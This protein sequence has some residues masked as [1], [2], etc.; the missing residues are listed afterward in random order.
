MSIDPGT[1]PRHFLPLC[2]T[3]P[4]CLGAAAALI[5]P[6]VPTFWLGETAP[7][8]VLALIPQASD[9]LTLSVLPARK[10]HTLLGQEC[11]LLVFDA[12]SG[13]DVNAFAA[14][15][16][17][18]VGGGTLVLLSP[19]WDQWPAFP[20]P[21]YRRF[22]PWPRTLA[23]VR[24]RFLARLVRVLAQDRHRF[25]PLPVRA[26][27]AFDPA[28]GDAYGM[29]HGYGQGIHQTSPWPAPALRVPTPAQQAAMDT[30]LQASAPVTLTADRGRG[31]SALLGLL[32]TRLQ[33]QGRTPILCAP[34][35]QTAITALRHAVTAPA[36]FAPDELLQTLPAAD[37]LLVDEAAAIPVPLLA[38]MV[39]HYPR[40]V[41][42]TTVHGYE[43]S[44]RGF[45]LRFQALLASLAPG[46]QALRLE[47]P[48]RWVAGDALEA[49][50]NRVLLLDLEL[51]G[52]AETGGL[53]G[54][55]DV[56]ADG[57]TPM[58]LDRDR[59]AWDEVL[60]QQ[61][62]GLLVT[63]HY[64]TRPSDL[65]QL[66][67]APGLSVHAL[68]QAGQVLAVGVLSREGGFDPA[69]A[70]AIHTGQRRPHGHPVPQSL[71][72]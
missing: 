55:G 24:G 27:R 65:R 44:G 58:Q 57:I 62:F 71:C 23:D 26:F 34:S 4:D 67:D 47:K 33:Q 52:I 63:A 60:L 50:V 72:F 1:L 12:F 41:F 46:W 35:R 43:G 45:V 16:G 18:L 42:A 38:R 15:L 32:A 48:L 7:A 21:D 20:D 51:A 40:S 14:V 22:L 8:A 31:K 53:A 66:L 64:Q 49:W 29:M 5:Q 36:F 3:Q 11:G 25:R 68:L 9:D 69:L 6:S 28:A 13:F 17:T 19:P 2:G 30:I 70:Q 54:D 39:Q 10:A 37:V 59:L 61:V 56:P